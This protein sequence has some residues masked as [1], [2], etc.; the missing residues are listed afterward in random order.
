[1]N[2]ATGEP[3]AFEVLLISPLFER[4]VLPF[5][6]NLSRLGID[7]LVRTVDTAQYRERLTQ[8]DYDMV[9]GSWGQS[10]SPG[11]EQRDYWTT[12]AASRP[13]SRNLSGIADPAIDELVEL[14]IAAPTRASLVARTRALDRALQWS[15][16]LVP[17]WHISYDRIARW[18]KFGMPK[19]IPVQ[20]VVTGAWWIDPEK[21]A[22]LSARKKSEN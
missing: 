12:E 10:L 21:E 9:V 18:D 3:F 20:G 11:N 22:A 15:H 7:V 17:H 6:K 1:M 13:R 16:L 2:G 8:F 5:K 14:L 19:T 4:I